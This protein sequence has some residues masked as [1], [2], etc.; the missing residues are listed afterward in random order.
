MIAKFTVIIMMITLIPSCSIFVPNGIEY[1]HVS[2]YGNNYEIANLGYFN[3]QSIEL[4][5][6]RGGMIEITFSTVVDL[7]NFANRKQSTL[8][9]EFYTCKNH[10]YTRIGPLKK[11]YNDGKYFLGVGII[12]DRAKI[13][14]TKNP[15]NKY[16]YTAHLD[17][18]V[19]SFKS[20]PLNYNLDYLQSDLCFKLTGG[21]M[22]GNHLK[23]NIIRIPIDDIKRILK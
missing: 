9:G 6:E 17:R 13:N 1:E 22:I 4:T 11:I 21:T 12:T 18:K 19:E 20:E 7:F 23:S 3:K 14:S 8:W 2:F 5:S 16:L 10:D 15:S